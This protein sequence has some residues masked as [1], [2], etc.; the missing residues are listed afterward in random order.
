M[1]KIGEFTARVFTELRPVLDWA[2]RNWAVTSIVVV[3]LITGPGNRSA[4]IGINSKRN[5]VS[6]P[7]PFSSNRQSPCVDGVA[8]PALLSR[9]KC[10]GERCCAPITSMTGETWQGKRP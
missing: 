10:A 8:L 9:E 7:R 4:S 2:V 3:I 6:S 5:P 1:D